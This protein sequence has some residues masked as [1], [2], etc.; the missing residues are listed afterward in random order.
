MSYEY[1][2]GYKKPTAGK[3]FNIGYTDPELAKK[4]E[5]LT[6]MTGQTKSYWGAVIMKYFFDNVDVE[7]LSVEY[8]QIQADRERNIKELMAR[9]IVPPTLEVEE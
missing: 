6:Q 5:A 3:Q 9:V 7:K 8:Q 2:Y 1:G 4:M